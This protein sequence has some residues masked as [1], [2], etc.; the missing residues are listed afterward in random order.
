MVLGVIRLN[1]SRDYDSLCDLANEH[2]TL[3]GI[4]GVLPSDGTMG[5]ILKH[6]PLDGWRKQKSW[7]RRFRNQARHVSRIA[8]GGGQNKAFRLSVP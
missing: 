6:L 7:A 1:E 2:Y 4:L 3:R 5:H 8:G